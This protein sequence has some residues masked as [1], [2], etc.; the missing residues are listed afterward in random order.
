MSETT[1]A[2]EYTGA[3]LL[4]RSIRQITEHPES[5]NQEYWAAIPM[6][7]DPVARVADP[8]SGWEI[9]LWNN[10]VTTCLAG[11]ACRLAEENLL[12]AHRFDLELSP[13]GDLDKLLSLREYS[14][15]IIPCDYVVGR[16]E[17]DRMM[18][19]T[20]SDRQYD[21]LRKTMVAIDDEA[22]QLLELN[23][24]EQVDDLF[25][26]CSSLTDLHRIAGEILAQRD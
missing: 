6:S 4:R 25:W 2:L 26:S 1:E 20:P 21:K 3:G 16:D 17:F 23:D 10:P 5:W 24:Q 13:S 11:T 7:Q 22:A 14:R 9:W 15:G 8:E 19:E 12:F 18:A